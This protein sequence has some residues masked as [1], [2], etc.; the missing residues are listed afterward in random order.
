LVE[1]GL[2]D[3]IGDAKAV[4]MRNLSGTCGPWSRYLA[5]LVKVG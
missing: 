4:L 3:I 2:A 1:V 5:P